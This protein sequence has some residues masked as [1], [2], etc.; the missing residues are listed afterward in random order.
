MHAA[1]VDV[2]VDLLLMC[3]F[4]STGLSEDS[5]GRNVVGNVG[6]RPAASPDTGRDKL[7][8]EPRQARD[9]LVAGS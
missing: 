6:Q 1:S 8:S 3:P 9:R 2:A 5:H 4:Q 7:A